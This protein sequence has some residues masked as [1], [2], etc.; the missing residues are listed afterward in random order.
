LY[1]PTPGQGMIPR[2]NE[3]VGAT[4]QIRFSEKDGRLMYE[5]ESQFA[6]MEIEGDTRILQTAHNAR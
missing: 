5:G 4:V 3:S 6:G 2:V 1:A